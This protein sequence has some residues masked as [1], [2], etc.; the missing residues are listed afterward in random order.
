MKSVGF[1]FEKGVEILFEICWA[2]W[3][4]TEV[5]HEMNRKW[6][7]KTSMLFGPSTRP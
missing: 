3:L 1:F 7:Y 6:A 5:G 4:L 2:M